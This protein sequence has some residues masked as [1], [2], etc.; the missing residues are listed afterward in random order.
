[1]KF[2]RTTVAASLLSAALIGPAS[3]ANI[4]V[5]GIVDAGA[6]TGTAADTTGLSPLHGIQGALSLEPA[7]GPDFVDMFKISVDSKGTLVVRTGSSFSPWL[8][9]DPVLYLFDALGAGVAMDDESGGNAQAKLKA[10]LLAGTYYLAIAY[11]GVEPLD[12]NG[13][14]IFDAF[15]SLDV[16]SGNPLASWLEAP[17][18]L[19][20]ATVGDYQMSVLVP[21][22]GTLG[23]VALALLGLGA[24][25]AR[26]RV[27]A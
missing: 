18:A 6:S 4:F 8:I 19:D 26:R 7:N 2:F 12:G 3:A 25:L 16:I 20:P 11:A 17:F 22:P 21:E 1:M 27:A 5:E 14:S 24:S 23:L 10:P 13:A 15:G 9:A